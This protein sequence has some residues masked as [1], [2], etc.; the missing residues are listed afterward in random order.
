[1][2]KKYY[3]GKW[4]NRP[5]AIAWG[6][7]CN[8]LKFKKIFGNYE[9]TGFEYDGDCWPLLEFD[10]SFTG[11]GC[12]SNETIGEYNYTLLERSVINFVIFRTK[13]GIRKKWKVKGKKVEV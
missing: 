9:F 6:W 1:M 5:H 8:K 7:L 11:Y 2:V 4:V 12:F 10:C 13:F 3:F